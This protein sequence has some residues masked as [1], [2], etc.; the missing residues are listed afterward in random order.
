MNNAYLFL[1]FLGVLWTLVAIV[2][3]EA[4]Q[5]GASVNH[6]YCFGSTTAVILLFLAGCSGPCRH[7][8][9]LPKVLFLH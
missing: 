8:L 3:S 5:R 7:M 9:I 4:K 2:L 1:A 6:F